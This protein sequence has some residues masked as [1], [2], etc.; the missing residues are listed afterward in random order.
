MEKESVD[1]WSFGAALKAMKKGYRMARHGWNG[2]GMYVYLMPENGFDPVFLPYIAM[3][4]VD[5]KIVPWLASQTDML[6]DD[7]YIVSQN[8][9]A[10]EM[11]EMQSAEK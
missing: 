7:W 3:K 11:L 2:K 5:G 6:T 4:T 10:A 1:M 8:R 9:V